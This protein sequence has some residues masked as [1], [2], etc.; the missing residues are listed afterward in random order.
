MLTRRTFL[1]ATAAALPVAALLSGPSFAAQPEVFAT[2]DVAINGYDPVAYFTASKPVQ[3]DAA[4]S[5]DHNGATWLFSSAE[6]KAAFEADPA[7]YAPQFGGYCA[8]A[9]SKGYTAPTDPNAWSVYEGKLYLNYSLRAR[10]LWSED[11]PGNITKGNANWPAV[12]S[13]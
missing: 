12:L 2:G 13:Q 4:H 1:T 9:V 8:Y 5:A 6:N 3:G 10:D 7:K 11:V